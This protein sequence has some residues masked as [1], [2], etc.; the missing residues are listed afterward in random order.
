MKRQP[1]DAHKTEP[2]V[3]PAPEEAVVPAL[4]QS[5]H[6]VEFIEANAPREEPSTP[7]ER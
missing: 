7:Q 5:A 6:P 4:A 3:E 1:A 2:L